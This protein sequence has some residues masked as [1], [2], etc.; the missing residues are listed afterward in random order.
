MSTKET[1]DVNFFNE[2]NSIVAD[3]NSAKKFTGMV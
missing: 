3:L 1:S 2:S